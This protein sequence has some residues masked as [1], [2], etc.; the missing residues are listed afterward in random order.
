MIFLDK[1]PIISILIPTFKRVWYLKETLQS[2]LEQEGFQDWD[3]EIIISDNDHIS[4]SVRNMLHDFS[5]SRFSIIYNQNSENIWSVKNFNQLLSLKNGIFFIIMSDDD[6]FY[7]KNSLYQLYINLINDSTYTNSFWK[8][9][10]FNDSGININRVHPFPVLNLHSQL[11]NHTIWFWWILYK[12]VWIRYKESAGLYCDYCFNIDYITQ[13]FKFLYV[14]VKT[15]KYRIHDTQSISRLSVF[16]DIILYR[17]MLSSTELIF[18][19]RY[20]YF[21]RKCL[22]TMAYLVKKNILWKK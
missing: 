1:M 19:I 2:C 22:I 15:F 17:K 21:V 4:D 9:V 16:N 6:M 13:G 20:Y 18:L 8:L 12:D 3:I 14:D 11:K 5:N 7:D 10:Y